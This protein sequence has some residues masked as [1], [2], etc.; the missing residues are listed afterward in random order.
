VEQIITVPTPQGTTEL[1]IETFGNPA[2]PLMIQIEGHMAQLISTPRSYCEQLAERGFH[3][4]RFDNRDVGRSQRFP[5][6]AYTLADMADDVHGLITKLGGGP[7]YVCGRSMGGQIAQLLALAYPDDVAGLVLFFTLAR[8][9]RRAPEARD[10]GSNESSVA[11]SGAGAEETSTIEPEPE[12]AQFR[13][14]EDFVAWQQQ[15]LP[16][17]A[18]RNYPFSKAAIDL[19]AREMWRRGVDTAGYARQTRAMA[20]TPPWA[21]RLASLTIPS[22]V[23][24][25]DE[26]CVIPISRGRELVDRLPNVELLIVPGMGHQQPPELDSYFVDAVVGLCRRAG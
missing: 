22:L 18:G 20:I 25:G 6:V 16:G 1:C 24:H 3:V 12:W 15:T 17:T 23:I 21:D 7:A 9:K 4:V 19:L 11:A 13:D 5:G 14:E 26:D 2:D 10:D 8:A